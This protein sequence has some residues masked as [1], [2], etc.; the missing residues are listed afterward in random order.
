MFSTIRVLTGDAPPPPL[1]D[2]VAEI[3]EPLMLI[4]AGIKEERQFNELYAEAAP[5]A[6]H[7]DVDAGHTAALRERPR[8]YEERVVGFLDRALNPGGAGA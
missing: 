7:W 5:H 1:Q 8:E 2:Q 3:E 6:E 4:G